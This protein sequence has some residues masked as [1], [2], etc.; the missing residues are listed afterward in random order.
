MES[1]QAGKKLLSD[2]ASGLGVSIPQP[3]ALEDTELNFGVQIYNQ[4]QYA[5]DV[6][7]N[8]DTLAKRNVK[9]KLEQV[10]SNTVA[11]NCIDEGNLAC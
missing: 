4:R 11:V 1:Q 6:C 3:Q 7:H 8:E 2:T 5:R 9:Q 10:T